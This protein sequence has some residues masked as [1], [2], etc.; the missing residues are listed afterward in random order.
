[1]SSDEKPLDGPSRGDAIAPGH[2]MAV[3]RRANID[4]E[5]KGALLILGSYANFEDNPDT[6][7]GAG[8]DVHP[9]ADRYA[10]DLRKSVATARRYLKWAR[11]VGVIAL[12]RR[13]NRRKRLCD[14]YRLTLSVEAMERI[15][16]PDPT[17]YKEMIGEAS[18][19]RRA[20]EKGARLRRGALG[21]GPD[22]VGLADP[23]YR[24]PRVSG[25]AGADDS[26]YRSACVSG[27]AAQVDGFP[28]SDYRS[29]PLSG[30]APISAHGGPA[31]PLTLDERT[32]YI[33]LTVHN[34]LTD[35]ETV[36]LHTTVTVA[37]AREAD[38]DPI[39][40]GDESAP[41]PRVQPEER[42]DEGPPSAGGP[43]GW[44]DLSP[45]TTGPPESYRAA[46]A[47]V[48]GP[49]PRTGRA[50][51]ACGQRNCRDGMLTIGIN[52]VRCRVC[53]PS[54]LDTERKEPQ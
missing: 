47:K 43:P 37:R 20:A 6:G 54:D 24:S 33:D 38:E 17:T 28:D 48:F 16:V 49:K 19:A 15:G 5:Q 31:L 34:S 25:N 30:N 45:R 4:L 8:E 10:Q 51:S 42:T 53:A 26:D 21:D 12:T 44:R 18:R 29:P 39:F 22:D 14:E 36:D 13:A 50:P 27:N 41:E 46:R 7:R 35:H 11:E 9:G 52:T 23:D 3:I 32:P 1:M 2:W 40:P